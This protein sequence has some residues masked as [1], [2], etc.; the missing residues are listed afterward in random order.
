MPLSKPKSWLQ[1][2]PCTVR[3]QGLRAHEELSGP[4]HTKWECGYRPILQ[5]RKTEPRVVPPS[6]LR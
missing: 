3:R 2:S 1:T 6:V 4:R 5:M